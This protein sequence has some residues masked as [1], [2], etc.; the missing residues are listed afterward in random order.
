M[1]P[2]SLVNDIFHL[3]HAYMPIEIKYFHGNDPLTVSALS[4]RLVELFPE[5]TVTAEKV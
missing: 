2:R 3:N 4:E 1:D 5:D